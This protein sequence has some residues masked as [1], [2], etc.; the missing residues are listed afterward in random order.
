MGLAIFKMHRHRRN[1]DAVYHSVDAGRGIIYSLAI[2]ATARLMRMPI[3]L[4]HHSFAYINERRLL[5][6]IMSWA[7]SDQTTHI[8]LCSCMH[9]SF[10]QKYQL[11]RNAIIVNNAFSLEFTPKV[12]IIGGDFIWVGHLS[13]LTVAKG[14]LI[15]LSLADQLLT[16]RK[17]VGVIIGGPLVDPEIKPRVDELIAKH[18]TRMQYAGPIYGESKGKFFSQTEVFV[19]PTLYKNEAQPL[20]LQEA[21]AAGCLIAALTRG[22][23]ASDFNFDGAL[24]IDQPEN[25]VSFALRW[26]SDLADDPTRRLRLRQ[27][28]MDRSRQQVALANEE[29]R[30]ISRQIKLLSPK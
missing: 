7:V 21:L 1:I 26:I 13:N 9:Q 27:E 8:F 19:F 29:V 11:K 18:G 16:S 14:A 28:N 4:H 2:C 6:T 5:M 3:F 17:D 15:F 24:I 20:V 22:C 25:F 12:P 30:D 10:D 23:I